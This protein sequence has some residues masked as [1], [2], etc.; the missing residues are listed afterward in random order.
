MNTQ[1]RMVACALAGAMM[2][3]APARGQGLSAGDARE[4]ARF[5]AVVRAAT[6]AGYA[7]PL[8]VGHGDSASDALFALLATRSGGGVLIALL[9]PTA[10]THAQPVEVER[11]QTP[12]GIGVRGIRFTV[13]LGD[14]S[15]TD[16]VVSH[17]P[18]MLETSRRFETHHL[19]RRS[20]TLL[21]SVCD[22]PGSDGSSS[23]K[24]MGS[25]T[26]SRHVT[27]ERTSGG[28]RSRF[29]VRTVDETTEQA[30]HQAAVVTTA[31]RESTREYYLPSTGACVAR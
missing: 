8:V 1:V 4:S 12:A 25:I 22:F 28:D 15:L 5:D 3:A 18:F 17:E 19:L 9:E 10:T 13:F 11:A 24:G 26:S 31:R 27:V 23:S 14:S 16:L 20:G 29:L 6:Q 30:P 2:L 21:A 7:N